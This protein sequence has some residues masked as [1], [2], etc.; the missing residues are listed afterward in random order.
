[1]PPLK[2]C[3]VWI[4]TSFVIT[5]REQWKNRMI[6]ILGNLNART[7]RNHREAFSEMGIWDGED[8]MNSNEV[9]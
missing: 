9:D 4:R 6:V 1:M 3:P 7:D 5:Y 8:V 2:M